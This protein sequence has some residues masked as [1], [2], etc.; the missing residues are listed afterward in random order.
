MPT[1]AVAEDDDHDEAGAHDPPAPPPLPPQHAA[2]VP[3]VAPTVPARVLPHFRAKDLRSRSAVCLQKTAVLFGLIIKHRAHTMQDRRGNT[4]IAWIAVATAAFRSDPIEP[5]PLAAHKIFE[6]HEYQNKLKKLLLDAAEYYADEAAKNS[7]KELLYE[8]E[9]N[10]ELVNNCELLGLQIHTER[11]ESLRVYKEQSAA[12]K[13]AKIRHKRDMEAAEGFVGAVAPGR[14]VAAPSGIVIDTDV[15][16]GLGHLGAQPRAN[17]GDRVDLLSVKSTDDDVSESSVRVVERG[18]VVTPGKPSAPANGSNVRDNLGKERASAEA[19]A[20][21]SA[22]HATNS[23]KKKK[24]DGKKKGGNYRI[25]PGHSDM[26]DVLDGVSKKMLQQGDKMNEMLDR[27]IPLLNPAAGARTDSDVLAEIKS[28]DEMI[29]NLKRSKREAQKED[30][31]D[32]VRDCEERIGRYKKKRNSL[33]AGMF[34][35]QNE[36]V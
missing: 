7:A 32:E 25:L 21:V 27:C 34:G 23:K 14:G 18:G 24:N 19:A 4:K 29:N 11:K 17:S 1:R 22:E 20:K 33:E 12:V 3:P 13:Q 5:G 2:A 36:V 6:G 26:V 31:A 10:S 16:E 8:P 15:A 28:C 9:D 30:D 35:T